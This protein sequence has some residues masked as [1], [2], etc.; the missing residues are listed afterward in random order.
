[1]LYA[2]VQGGRGILGTVSLDGKTRTRLSEPGVDAREPA[3]GP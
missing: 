2:T 3:W 1:V